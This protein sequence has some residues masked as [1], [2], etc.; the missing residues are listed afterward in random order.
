MKL[1]EREAY[2][3][4]IQNI[5][6]GISMN[7]GHTLF[8][9]GEAGVG[10]TSLV[11]EF[12]GNLKKSILILRGGCDS[13][14][15]PRPLGPLFDISGDFSPEFQRILKSNTNRSALFNSFLEELKGKRQTVILIFEDVHWAD[16]ATLDLIKYFSRRVVM[17]NCLFILTYRDDEI[18][19]DHRLRTILGEIPSQYQTRMKIQ[20]LSVDAVKELSKNTGMN[21]EEVY[22][23]TGGNAFYVTEILAHYSPGIPDNV[24]D[25]IL[26]VF[27]RQPEKVRNLWELIS[28]LSG[29]VDVKLLELIVPNLYTEVDQCLKSGVLLM[30]GHHLVFKHELYRKTIEE[31]LTAYKK[32]QLNSRVL[33]VL[34]AN[35]DE[36][37]D[38]TLIVHHAKNAH[39]TRVVAEFAPMAALDASIH[40]AHCEAA[41]LF[42]TAIQYSDSKEQLLADLYEKYAYECY[43]TNQISVAIESQ[44]K[45]L[46]IWS[47]LDDKT[48]VGSSLRLLSRFYWFE[49][50]REEAEKYALEAITVLEK[51][52]HLQET[53]MAYSNYA[54][55]K[56][57]SNEKEKTL[58]YGQKAIDLANKIHDEEILCHAL[59]NIGSVIFMADGKL[60]GYLNQ[61][62]E[63]ALR[64]GFQEHIARAY[65]NMASDS[66]LHKLYPEAAEFLQQGL[67][68]SMQRDLDSWTYYMLTWKARLH[69]E[70]CEWKEAE[71]IARE[72]VENSSHPATIRIGALVICGRLMIRKGD[73]SG[74][75]HLEEA[76]KLALITKELQR[77]IPVAVA[78]LEYGWIAN[79]PEAFSEI[80]DT[81]VDL[82]NITFV[83]NFYSELAYWL[84][85][86]TINSRISGKIEEPYASAISGNWKKAADQWQ[87]LGCRYE[88][89]LALCDGS[90]DA[91]RE[92]LIL[93]DQLGAFG[94]LELMK[95]KLRSRGIR[96]IPRGPRASTKSNSAN[97]TSRQIDVLF[98]ILFKAAKL[99]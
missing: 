88:Y 9:A 61:S 60:P 58:E 34:L 39:N 8:I 24:K 16:E 56:M 13:L 96:N 22:R 29:K 35:H 78:L 53:A 80:V 27:Y 19:Q 87:K 11:K 49:G 3:H 85:K 73:F 77:I 18:S 51:G 81:A 47:V 54:Q 64:N 97:L 55:L 28:T 74:L 59:N 37:S 46:S 76:K 15:T 26:S 57:L 45:A 71:S 98:C 92:A 42:R 94:T 17:V 14:F 30:E 67:E 44:K 32:I 7:G 70:K 2:L 89:A 48:R 95:S 50:N 52:S 75:S 83:G 10:K 62:L 65:T 93:L 40:G 38:M 4:T 86:N 68:Y 72:I 63:I 43:L 90:E 23:L 66:V 21:A 12:T 20:R 82:L 6:N 99:I 84:D 91:Q 33:D 1:L 25:S 31:A 36:G 79:D 41:K 5:F 69:F